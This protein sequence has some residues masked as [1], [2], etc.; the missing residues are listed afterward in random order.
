M[1]NF[2]KRFYGE[3]FPEGIPQRRWVC[4]EEEGENEVEESL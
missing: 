4:L 3:H 2:I 1:W